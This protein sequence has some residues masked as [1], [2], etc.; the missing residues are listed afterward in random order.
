MLLLLLLLRLVVMVALMVGVRG[1]LV[2][3]MVDGDGVMEGRTGD[4]KSKDA[5]E[6]EGPQKCFN[7]DGCRSDAPQGLLRLQTFNVQKL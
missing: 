2:V 1:M 5:A 4:D 3:G 6:Q 7:A